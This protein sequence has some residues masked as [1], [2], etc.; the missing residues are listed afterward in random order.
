M[1]GI[2]TRQDLIDSGTL[3]DATKKAYRA[4]IDDT[5]DVLAEPLDKSGS[6][7]GRGMLE[8]L[9]DMTP[10]ARKDILSR[11]NVVANIEDKIAKFKGP[12]AFEISPEEIKT[13]SR[14]IDTVGKVIG[15]AIGVAQA[16]LVA[17]D[18]LDKVKAGQS[19]KEAASNPEVVSNAV[20]GA[21]GYLGADAGATLGSL[22]PG[23]VPAKIGAELAGAVGG[24]YAG[25][26]LA[27]LLTGNP[28]VDK[29]LRDNYEK[30]RNERMA[31]TKPTAASSV[32]LRQGE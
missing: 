5:M 17:Q 11:P 3:D 15:P 31:K 22:V 18:V 7:K 4:W 12:S 26:K 10:E 29:I 30:A 27:D 8:M 24:G 2:K 19:V 20:R 25:A 14:G 13:V 23:G 21:L 6:G 1:S 28:I 32:Q 16:G 9:K